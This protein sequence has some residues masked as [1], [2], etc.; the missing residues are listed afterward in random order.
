M[1]VTSD[2][3]VCLLML[4]PHRVVFIL[5]PS[6]F[7]QPWLSSNI[8]EEADHSHAEMVYGEPLRLS[9]QFPAIVRSPSRCSKD[10]GL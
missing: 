8:R 9:E 2:Y 4:P 7:A 1:R 6:S 10:E 3:R 5:I